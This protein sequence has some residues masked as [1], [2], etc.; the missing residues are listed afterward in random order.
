MKN[1]DEP[2]SGM[3]V[4]H[5]M[6]KDDRRWSDHYRRRLEKIT[7]RKDSK[8]HLPGKKTTRRKTHHQSKEKRR[9]NQRSSAKLASLS[10]I[11][12][13]NQIVL[14]ILFLD[15]SKLMSQMNHHSW[16]LSSWVKAMIETASAIGKSV[17]SIIKVVL[18]C[19]PDYDPVSKTVYRYNK[20]DYTKMEDIL[21]IE[22][23]EEFSNHQ[24]DV[25]TQWDIF[26]SRDSE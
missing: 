24:G 19:S 5:D 6:S 12:L 22:W 11:S 14:Y 17:H 15:M 13:V 20:G 4:K 2:F 23:E 7:A 9:A 10:K 18:N 16:T 21:N 1:K 26:T 8:F 3:I 25:Q